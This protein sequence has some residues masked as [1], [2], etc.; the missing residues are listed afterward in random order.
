MNHQPLNSGL[1]ALHAYECLRRH[2]RS[3]PEEVSQ[4]PQLRKSACACLCAV[5]RKHA[6]SISEEGG[7]VGMP[8]PAF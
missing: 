2:L 8:E 7:V 4:V 5:C 3:G 6:L 1:L